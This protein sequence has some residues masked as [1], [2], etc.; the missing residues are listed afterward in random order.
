MTRAIV[1]DAAVR[2]LLFWACIHAVLS[3]F[4]APLVAAHSW[5]MP[6]LIAAIVLLDQRVC[7]ESVF[8]ANIGV[9]ASVAPVAAG[10][11]GLLL[12]LTLYGVFA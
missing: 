12:E 6:P 3:L 9:G 7:R 8:L 4:G 1:T 11:T 2:A 10:I 5:A